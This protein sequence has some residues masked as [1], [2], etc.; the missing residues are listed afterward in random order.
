MV[1]IF[2]ATNFV[3]LPMAINFYVFI[4]DTFSW[5]HIS[6]VASYHNN[7]KNL[8][9]RNNGCNY[10]KIW[11][12]WH[13]KD[14]DKVA[15]L[16]DLGLHCLPR[17]EACHYSQYTWQMFSLMK[18]TKLNHTQKINRFTVICRRA[19]AW[20]NQQNDLCAQRRL[21]PPRLIWVFA[22]RT[23]CLALAHNNVNF[24]TASCAL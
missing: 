13:S 6:S 4:D 11:K 9:I 23:V 14:A 1:Y 5:Q 24:P 2:M 19:S 7:L 3:F 10:P 8:D 12:V 20:Q 16:S 15:L 17:P 18:V 21:G 22:G